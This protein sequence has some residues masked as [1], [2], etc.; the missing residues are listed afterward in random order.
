MIYTIS[1]FFKK[2]HFNS[3]IFPSS[4]KF[5]APMSR[6]PWES[7]IRDPDR[8]DPW[9]IWDEWR[10]HVILHQLVIQSLLHRGLPQGVQPNPLSGLGDGTSFMLHKDL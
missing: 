8:W 4:L 2:S 3:Q 1:Q 10:K 6:K 5:L 7:T 9:D